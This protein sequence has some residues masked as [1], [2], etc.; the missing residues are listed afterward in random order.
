MYSLPQF[1]CAPVHESTWAMDIL[2]QEEFA[3]YNSID[4]IPKP[5]ID[6]ISNPE[7]LIAI[8]EPDEEFNETSILDEGLSSRRLIFAGQ[9]DKHWFIYYEQGEWQRSIN[10]LAL[11]QFTDNMVVPMIELE[12]QNPPK[13]PDFKVLKH[14]IVS[15]R[16]LLF[17]PP[18]PAQSLP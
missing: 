11:F 13:V 2:L 12:F 9:S 1:S 17:Y 8:A 10:K 4:S 6:E 3:I 14:R 18:D 16:A 7:E 15:A 5:I